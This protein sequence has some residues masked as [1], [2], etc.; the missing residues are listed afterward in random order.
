MSGEKC[1]AKLINSMSPA[2]SNDIYVY[3]TLPDAGFDLLKELNPIA[4]FREKEGVTLVLSK[5][6]AEQ[7]EIEYSGLF[8]LITLNVHSSLQAVGLTAAV[9]KKLAEGNISANIFAAYYHDHIFIPVEDAQRAI[10]CLEA[11]VK[12]GN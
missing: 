11:L 3:A 7:N 12:N 4:T 2:L 8:S 6:A 9:S 10:E 5:D 1:L